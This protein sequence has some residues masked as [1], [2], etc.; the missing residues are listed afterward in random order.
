[1]PKWHASVIEPE[2]TSPGPMGIGTTLGWTNH[3]MGLRMRTAA[4]VTE[5]ELNKKW[6]LNFTVGGSSLVENHLL[7]DPLEGGT[8][9]TMQYDMKVIGFSKLF[10]PLIVRSVRKLVKEALNSIKS[11][12][13]AQT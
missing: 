11:I 3:M 1:M 4:K 13:E 9:F 7:F 6:S 5:Y 10:S 8:K 12:L 2:Q